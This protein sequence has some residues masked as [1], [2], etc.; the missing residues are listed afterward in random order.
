MMVSFVHLLW[1]DCGPFIVESLSDQ[2]LIATSRAAS[3]FVEWGPE[4]SSRYASLVRG[5]LGVAT[6]VGER[7][8]VVALNVETKFSR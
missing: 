5:Q 2:G 7:Y 3:D 8:L 6:K 1:N 4:A